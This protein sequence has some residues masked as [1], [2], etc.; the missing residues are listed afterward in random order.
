MANECIGN[1]DPAIVFPDPLNA[2][3]HLTAHRSA[4]R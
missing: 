2:R 4:G 1:K 3:F